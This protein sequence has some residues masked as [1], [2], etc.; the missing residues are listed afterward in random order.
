MLRFIAGFIFFVSVFLFVSVYISPEFFPYAGLLTLLIPFLIVI[1]AIL[2]VLL[3]LAKRKLAFLPLIALAIGWKF[4]GITFQLNTP[5]E[6]EPNLTILSYNVHM[7]NYTRPGQNVQEVTKNITKWLQDDNSDIKCFQEFYQDY[8]TPSRNAIK[9]IGTERGYE[10][11]YQVVDGNISKR[12]FGLAIFSRYPIINEG[13]VFDTKRNNGVIFA[14]IVVKKDTI[15]I[16]NAHLESMAISSEGLTD[17]DGIKENYRETLGK[18]KRGQVVRASQLGVLK[19]HMNNSPYANILV[20]DFND[21]PYSYTYFSLRKLMNNAFE[22]AGR[23][24]GFTYNKILFFL[25]IDNIFYDDPLEILEFRTHNEVDYSDHY[26]VSAK[27]KWST[28]LVR[29]SEEIE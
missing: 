4:I 22:K 17:I 12:S 24:F 18:L 15:R 27:F 6:S 28:P 10:F 23:G 5:K 14:D 2:F 9:A 20:G 16:Y 7:L 26:P 8:T 21:V 29:E 11:T 3:V 25:R 19:E 1:N 13:K